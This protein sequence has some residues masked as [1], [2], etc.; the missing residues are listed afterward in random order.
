MYYVRNDLQNLFP[1]VKNGEYVKLLKWVLKQIPS[2]EDV[3]ASI[4][5][6]YENWYRELLKKLNEW[7]IMK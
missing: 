3:H 1:E 6:L 7:F 4:L 2:N 5:R